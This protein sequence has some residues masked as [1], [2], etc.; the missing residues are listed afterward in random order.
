MLGWVFYQ[1]APPP[2]R[3]QA[4]VVVDHNLEEAWVYYPDRALFQFLQ[5]E[6]EHLEELAWSD[7]VVATIAQEVS[8]VSVAQLRD[9]VL[10]LSHPSDGGWHF[11]ADHP[12]SALAQQVAGAWALAFTQAARDAVA[13]SP[14]LQ[15]ARAELDA[16]LAQPHPD[17]QRLQ[18][19]LDEISFLAEHTRGISPFVEIYPSQTANLPVQRSVS[20]ATYMLAG[21]ATLAASAAVYVLARRP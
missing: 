1:L 14:E 9:G 2:Y 7:V 17:E 12:D 4:T 20:L 21:S 5:R 19:L 13:A 6:T 15:S 11:Y 3:A 18:E 16:E 8:S 10:Q